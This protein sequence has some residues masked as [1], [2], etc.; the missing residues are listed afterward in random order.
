MKS[1]SEDIF[2][3]FSLHSFLVFC[4]VI[5]VISTPC[6]ITFL[7]SRNFLGCGIWCYQSTLGFSWPQNRIS[8]QVLQYPGQD[9]WCLPVHYLRLYDEENNKLERQVLSIFPFFFPSVKSRTQNKQQVSNS[10]AGISVSELW[11]KLQESKCG[12]KHE[13][14]SAVLVCKK[15]QKFCRWILCIADGKADSRN[16]T[17][18]TQQGWA[19]PYLCLSMALDILSEV[20]IIKNLDTEFFM[21]V[22]KTDISNSWVSPQI[23]MPLKHLWNFFLKFFFLKAN[24]LLKFCL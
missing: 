10:T 11:W 14:S 2:I 6:S 20:L 17:C 22:L 23:L 13:F 24:T 3:L 12:I 9:L 1:Q 18:E 16:S 4:C 5:I 15:K 21:V 7:C 19:C 8:F